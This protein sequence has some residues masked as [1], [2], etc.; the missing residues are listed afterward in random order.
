MIREATLFDVPLLAEL[1]AEMAREAGKDPDVPAWA[2]QQAEGLR[3][4]TVLC[5][6]CEDGFC[7]GSLLYEPGDREMILVGRHLFVRPAA[8]GGAL[9]GRLMVRLLALARQ[10]GASFVLTHGTPSAYAVQQL[11]GKKMEML[12]EIRGVRL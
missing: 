12:R 1:W 3:T 2:A 4:G 6:V 8:R 9:G 7:D 5:A 10:S 11:L